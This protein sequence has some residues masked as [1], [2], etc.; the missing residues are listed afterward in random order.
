MAVAWLL[1]PLVLLA[2]CVGCGL[3]VERVGSWK[4]P[5]SVLPA[6]GLALV[7]VVASLGTRFASTAPLTPA[8][9]VV[10]ALAGYVSS[11]QRL[12]GLRPEPW[13]LAVGL[14]VFAVCAAPIVLSGNATFL[15]YFILNDTAFHFAFVDQLL[16]HGHDL[17]GLTPSA[18][19]VV[20]H[21]YLGDSYPT[22]ADVALGV[23]RALVRQ[24]VASL[25]QPYLAAILALGGAALYELLRDVVR[26][27]AL[28]AACA[29]VAAQPGLVY[30]YYLEASIKEL[31]TAW[32]I[33]VMVVFVVATLRQTFA[34]RRCF[35]LLIV[36]VAG[37]D[38]LNL[39][40]VPWL[41]PPLAVFV[42]VLAWR[43]RHV[44]RRMGRR[45]LAVAAGGGAIVL[46]ALVVVVIGRASTFLT[47]ATA[48]LTEKHDL[49]NLATPLQKWQILGIWPSGDFRFPVE[50]HYR[51]AYALIGVA[52]ASALL[53]ALWTCRRRA[54]A[55]LLMIAGNG[56]AA[57]YLLTR[58]SP[59]ASAKVMMIFSITAVLA[60]MLGAAALHDAGRRIE[61]WLLA[62]V[63]AGGVLW[64]NALAYHYSSVAPEDR[65]AELAAIGSRFTGQGPA[66]FNLSD[67]FAMHFLRGEAV[68]DPYFGRLPIQPA[69][70]PLRTPFQARRL[71]WD[72]DDLAPT[73]L[74]SFP[75]LV[76]G[77]SADLSRPPADY[78]LV[79]QGRYYDVWRR[80]ATPD[81]LEHIP[82]GSGSDPVAVPSC[83][84]V[85]ATARRAAGDHARLAFVTRAPAPTLVPIQATHPANWLPVGSDPN[86][87]IPGRPGD[88]VT[89]VVH[90]PETG[91][92][93]VWLDGSFGQRFH[94]WVGRQFVGSVSDEIGPP[95]Q[96]I[97][98]G[99]L[100]LQPGDQP[101]IIERQGAGLAPD[102]DDVH[103]I[104]RL[105]GPL[106]LA[107]DGGQPAVSEID[108]GNAR[109]LCGRSLD[110][111]E[112]VS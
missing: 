17:A 24:D 62:A 85:L 71:P 39:A 38:V 7:I 74:Q 51:I 42:V 109:S 37:L 103:P 5:G 112:I 99:H 60:A 87:L 12:R 104:N 102:A 83:R 89:G 22:G 54:Y 50:T 10:L 30:A 23:V 91:H 46:A 86:E 75:L 58:A 4:V 98:V 53:G 55:P 2:V 59:Y 63:I 49:G 95:G 9:I 80:T 78:R 16:V 29:F 65:F 82:L 79:Y 106:M 11:W 26:S 108:P 57:A 77:R 6:V 96:A 110:W 111:I 19:S 70:V 21:Q 34:L 31:A 44:I 52:I 27:R 3:V 33:T 66:F 107:P 88:A 41:G 36:T 105:L 28:R 56:V 48:V 14:G 20:L 18:Y 100:T 35:P 8:L 97:L 64:T 15:G 61:G 13:A 40:I 69:G 1:F 45:R 90:V 32:I 101:V 92:Y 67:E 25:F 84:M 73:Y 72:P 93:Q 81:V 68:T 47:V 43:A 94:V 76:L